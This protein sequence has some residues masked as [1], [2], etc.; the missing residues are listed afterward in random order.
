M[1]GTTNYGLHHGWRWL[2]A[3]TVTAASVAAQP[4]TSDPPSFSRSRPHR[5]SGDS[6]PAWS[7]HRATGAVQAARF[8]SLPDSTLLLGRYGNDT[9][10]WTVGRALAR[11]DELLTVSFFLHVVGSWDGIHDND[12]FLVMVGDSTVFRESFSNTT[13]R[14]SYPGRGR[15]RTFPQRTGARRRNTLPF[16]FRE[17]G[18]YDGPLDAS[19]WL[20]FNL[21]GTDAPMEVRLAGHLRDV[22][23]GIDNE[24]WAI[25]HMTVAIH[26]CPPEIVHAA[27]AVIIPV[28]STSQYDVDDV[29]IVAGYNDDDAFPG[30]LDST[31]R[32]SIHAT[33]LADGC[34]ACSPAGGPT[35]WTLYTDGWINL[36]YTTAPAGVAVWSASLSTSDLDALCALPS[37]RERQMALRS[38]L[39]ARG[40]VGAP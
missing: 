39:V 26:R 38:W 27:V 40:V 25:S 31:A 6:L 1:I 37:D 28:D 18:I 5:R 23:A 9:L 17:P 34:D 7:L 4:E 15:R 33:L 22:R 13:Y 20:E 30:L 10:V 29:R 21:R 36:W 12:Q 3:L 11:P 19:Y 35:S 14:Q 2:L 32:A 16:R 24:S 8:V